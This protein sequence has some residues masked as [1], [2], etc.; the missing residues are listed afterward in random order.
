MQLDTTIQHTAPARLIGAI[1][2]GLITAILVVAFVVASLGLGSE[3]I[4]RDGL[5][6]PPAAATAGH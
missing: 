1:A 4:G 2:G 6:V 5:L 3:G